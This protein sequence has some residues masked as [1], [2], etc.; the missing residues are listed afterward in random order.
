MVW[1]AFVIMLV[2]WGGIQGYELRV[3]WF[4]GFSNLES[5]RLALVVPD[6]ATAGSSSLRLCMDRVYPGLMLPFYW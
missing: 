1:V 6:E 3:F 5:L 4:S 2:I